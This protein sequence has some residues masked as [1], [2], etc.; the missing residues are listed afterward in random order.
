MR[1]IVTTNIDPLLGM[2]Q[3]T[4]TSLTNR[5][6]RRLSAP[7]FAV[8]SS[9]LEPVQLE[10][11]KVVVS[12]SKPIE[13]AYFLES[14]IVSVVASRADTR[15]IE[16]GIYG[17]EGMGGFPLLLGSDQSPHDQYMQLPGA[18]HRIKTAPFLAAVQQSATLNRLLLRYVHS[19]TT[20]TAQTA[21][22][23]SGNNIDERLARWLLMCHDR[24]DGDVLPLTHKFLS[25]MLGVRRAGVTDAVHILE[26]R[27]LIRAITNGRIE[28]RNREKLERLAGAA[29]GLPEAEYRR[30]IGAF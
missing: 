2:R 5:L 24:I 25:M 22:A 15:V 21:L 11:Y 18:G 8:L 16:V 3:I 10:L 4:Q 28:I 12:A 13:H 1:N 20:Q 30:L 27:G 26:G 29:Y 19:F 14:G 7:D 9:N 17:R 23:N 6:L